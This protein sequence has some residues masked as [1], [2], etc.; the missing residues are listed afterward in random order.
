MGWAAHGDE[1]W[2]FRR[3][4]NEEL[5]E[6]LRRTVRKRSEEF[7]RAMHYGLFREGGQIE[8]IAGQRALTS[9]A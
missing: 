2:G 3:L 7:P 1:C 6:K 4:S 5:K 8:L 9:E